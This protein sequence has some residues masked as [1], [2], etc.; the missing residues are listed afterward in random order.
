MASLAGKDGSGVLKPQQNEAEVLSKRTR[1]GKTFDQGGGAF[2]VGVSIGPVHYRED[3]F[4][5]VEAWK[6]IDLDIEATPGESWDYE[7]SK[8]G[9]QFRVWQE[10]NVA[11]HAL[12]YIGQFRRAG[13]WFGMAPIGL[14]WV[15]AANERQLIAKPTASIEPVVNNDA[16]YIIWRN[17]FGAGLD[18]GYDLSGV[19]HLVKFLRIRA[20]SDL[21]APTIGTAGLRL[22]LVMGLG[23]DAGAAAD[24]GFAGG[25]DCSEFP[26][27]EDWST[28]DEELE[29]PGWFGYED[30]RG[31]L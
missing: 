30:V 3:P 29:N 10:R 2:R 12:R 1:T 22:V 15:N 28:A 20:K 7:A 27:E 14:W 31:K 23:W 16:N 5:E 25:Q 11:G 17:C 24:N 21:P 9:W 18:F 26:A 8:N 19:T 13:R 6:E 4:S